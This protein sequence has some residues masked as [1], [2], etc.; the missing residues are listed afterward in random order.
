MAIRFSGLRNLILSTCYRW[1]RQCW[2]LPFV[3]LSKSIWNASKRVWI[4]RVLRYDSVKIYRV[5]WRD[6]HF[7]EFKVNQVRGFLT[8]KMKILGILM[9]IL[10]M[11]SL[12]AYNCHFNDAFTQ[13]P[14]GYMFYLF[15]FRSH[16][17]DRAVDWSIVAENFTSLEVQ[18]M[19]PH[20]T[21][22]VSRTFWI[23]LIQLAVNLLLVVFSVFMLGEFGWKAE[24]F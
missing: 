20:E 7:G 4:N 14:G 6:L 21:E 23:T 17:C 11:C 15:Y 1:P 24:S 16:H 8:D 22:T 12:L 9:S 3:G 18:P 10:A 13:S 19:M 5:F 2:C